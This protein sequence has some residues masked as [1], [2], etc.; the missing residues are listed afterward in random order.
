MYQCDSEDKTKREL[1]RTESKLHS[2]T[3]QNAI[4]VHYEFSEN[5]F[6]RDLSMLTESEC[7][8]IRPI[9]LQFRLNDIHKRV[10]FRSDDE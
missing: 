9:F 8:L 1:T 3:S 7:K 6:D 5:I 4:S 10:Q 2:D